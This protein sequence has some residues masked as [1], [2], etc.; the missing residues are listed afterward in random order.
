MFLKVLT[1]LVFLGILSGLARLFKAKEIDLDNQ[2][3]EL[4]KCLKCESYFPRDFSV[5]SREYQICKNCKS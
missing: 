3:N 5:I 1:V 2:N 4:I